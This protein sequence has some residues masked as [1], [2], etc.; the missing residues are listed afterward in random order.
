M[1]KHFSLLFPDWKDSL[2]LISLS[3]LHTTSDWDK[4]YMNIDRLDET[5]LFPVEGFSIQGCLGSRITRATYQTSVWHLAPYFRWGSVCS[6]LPLTFA[7]E[8]GLRWSIYQNWLP[9]RDED[10]SFRVLLHPRPSWRHNR[11]KSTRSTKFCHSEQFR[12][13]RWG[14][15]SMA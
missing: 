2:I 5:K 11:L 8:L 15:M 4:C 6:V 3:S 14:R 9:L 12:P 7:C 13:L 1:V 10:N